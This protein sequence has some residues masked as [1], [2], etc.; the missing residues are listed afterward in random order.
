MANTHV[1]FY[2][3]EDQAG[4]SIALDELHACFQAAY[5]YRQRQ[6]VFILAASQEQAH[7]I[8]ELLWSFDPESFVPHNLLGEGPNNGSPVEISWQ[9]PTN[10]RNVLI[11]LTSTVPDFA[12]HFSNIVDFVPHQEQLKQL[13]RERFKAYRQLGFQIGNQ[14]AV[15]VSTKTD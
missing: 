5:F 10:R 3:L 6:R 9:A 4:H 12:Q 14:A 11:N 8:D 2:Q 7:Q 1:M 15:P 13:A